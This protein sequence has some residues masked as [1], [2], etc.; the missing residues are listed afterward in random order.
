MRNCLHFKESVKTNITFM[1][2]HLKWACEAPKKKN[3]FEIPQLLQ[4]YQLG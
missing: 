4:T 2:Q 3:Y 1:Q